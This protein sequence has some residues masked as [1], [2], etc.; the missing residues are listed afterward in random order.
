VFLAVSALLV[1]AA[2]AREQR[3]VLFY[4]VAVFIAFFCGLLAMA[5]LFRAEGRRILMTT[6]LLGAFAVAVTLAAD[7]ARGDPI[8]SLVSALMIAG[9][10]YALWVRA[11]RPGGIAEAE[12]LAESL[13]P[14][15]SPGQ[16]AAPSG[17]RQH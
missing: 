16:I 14:E 8:V 7:L 5:K 13:D 4:A 10:L 11:G 15:D 17:A 9:G 12:S 2:G 1:V 6:S 3:L